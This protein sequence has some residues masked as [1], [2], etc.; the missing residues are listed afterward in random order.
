MGS[1]VSCK[2]E[3]TKK[4]TNKGHAKGKAIA[5]KPPGPKKQPKQKRDKNESEEVEEEEGEEQDLEEQVEEIAE[6]AEGVMDAIGGFFG[7]SDD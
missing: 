4:P 5:G 2:T 7:G 6:Q 3:T 1:C